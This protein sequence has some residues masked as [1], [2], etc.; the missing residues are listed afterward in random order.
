[1]AARN[2]KTVIARRRRRRCDAIASAALNTKKAEAHAAQ[3]CRS[4][5]VAGVNDRSLAAQLC[6]N[7]RAQLELNVKKEKKNEK[8][9]T[10]ATT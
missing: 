3:I 9:K 4:R 1:M 5:S 8:K 7:A 6:K 10:C 2:L